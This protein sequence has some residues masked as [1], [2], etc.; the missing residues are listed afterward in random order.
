MKKQLDILVTYKFQQ[1][2][3]YTKR[4][5]DGSETRYAFC[6]ETAPEDR[7]LE[8]ETVSN[9]ATIDVIAN[10]L[11]ATKETNDDIVGVVSVT[12]SEKI[13]IEVCSV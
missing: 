12:C 13:L 5:L 8:V 1:L 3:Y 10:A 6:L 4:F 9:A 11:V 2:Q 7:R